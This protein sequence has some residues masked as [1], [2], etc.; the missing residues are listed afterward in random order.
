MT[1][2]LFHF[3]VLKQE[4]KKKNTTEIDT[5]ANRQTSPRT[6]LDSSNSSESDVNGSQQ[7]QHSQSQQ[8]RKRSVTPMYDILDLIENGNYENL[9]ENKNL[10]YY[11]LKK[12]VINVVSRKKWKENIT[13]YTFN[14]FIHP[15]DE[16]F[17]LIVLENNS[18]RY[19]EMA[20]REQTNVSTDDNANENEKVEY[21]QPLFT[22]VTKKGQRSSGKGWSKQGKDLLIDYTEFVKRKRRN[23]EWMNRRSEYVKNRALKDSSKKR[24]RSSENDVEDNSKMS[25]SE[26]QKWNKFIQDSVNDTEWFDNMV[27][28]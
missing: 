12:C 13:K 14:R 8:Q 3:L 28:V 20:E 26:E 27:G 9:Y 22:T 1:N 6:S 23:N 4:T 2:I 16:A 19:Q 18:K 10:H 11:F 7:D 17:A 24:K 21:S 25:T 15:S 5:E